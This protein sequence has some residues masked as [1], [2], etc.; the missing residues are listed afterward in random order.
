MF[1]QIVSYNSKRVSVSPG[2]VIK[3]RLCN[4]IIMFL[5]QPSFHTLRQTKYFFLSLHNAI[6]PRGHSMHVMHA[7]VI[8]ITQVFIIVLKQ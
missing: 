4:F 8:N 6:R 2:K 5:L 7:S 1:V 3:V